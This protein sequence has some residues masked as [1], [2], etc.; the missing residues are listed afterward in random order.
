MQLLNDAKQRAQEF[1]QQNATTLLTIGGV[2]GTVTTAVLA[3]RAGYKAAEI[4]IMEE[5]DR[6]AMALADVTP[7]QKDDVL[8][9]IVTTTD[10]LRLVGLQFVPPILTGTATIASIIMANRMSAQKAA[11]LAAA[12]GLSEKQFREYKDKVQEKLTGPKAQAI[13]DELAQDRVNNTPGSQQIVVVEGEVLC[14]DEATGRY[15]RGSMATI[16]TAV[17][18]TNEEILAHNYATASFYYDKLGLDPTTW[19]DEVGWNS[20]HPVE[21][22]ISTVMSHDQ[23]PCISI[24]FKFLPTVDYV[25]G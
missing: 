18:K 19:S 8:P 16:N 6:L 15:F 23:R 25:T 22:S 3:G 17:N 2:M 5:Q 9:E 14:F 4:I 7:D 21:I 11:A 10:K 12:Y 20:H 24:D 1:A 13:D